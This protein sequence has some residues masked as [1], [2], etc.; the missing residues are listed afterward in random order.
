MKNHFRKLF[1][2]VSYKFRLFVNE[3]NKNKLLNNTDKKKRGREKKTGIK[4]KF[5]SYFI[6]S[7]N[8]IDYQNFSLYYIVVCFIFIS[9]GVLIII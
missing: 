2:Q 4:I 3:E 7:T 5:L 8:F 9:T 6:H 1:G